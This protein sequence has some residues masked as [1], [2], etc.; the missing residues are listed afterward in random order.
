[1]FLQ[2]LLAPCT[3][4]SIYIHSFIIYT[5]YPVRASPSWYWV[6]GEVHPGQITS[7]L[8]G[9]HVETNNQSHLHSHSQFKTIQG[10]TPICMSLDCGRNLQY[11]EKSHT[12]GGENMPSSQKDAG[13]HQDSSQ[14][15]LLWG[16]SANHCITHAAVVTSQQLINPHIVVNSKADSEVFSPPWFPET[17]K[18]YLVD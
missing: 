18:N 12:D 1:M 8:Q 9:E 3:L 6:R 7:L 10:L 11:P 14:G 5:A 2:G 15:P 16:S 4:P 17:W 13:W